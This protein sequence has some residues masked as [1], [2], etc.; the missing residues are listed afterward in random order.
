MGVRA[1]RREKKRRYVCNGDVV[2]LGC[3][4]WERS[5]FL[6]CTLFAYE[7]MRR[8]WDLLIERND[9]MSIVKDFDMRKVF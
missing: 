4:C 5:V 3:R 7:G 9:F 6:F 2:A 8:R 1:R